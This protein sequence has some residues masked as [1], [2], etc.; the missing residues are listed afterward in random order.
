MPSS[1]VAGEKL[2]FGWRRSCQV[3]SAPMIAQMVRTVRASVARSLLAWVAGCIGGDDG[4]ARPTGR[5]PG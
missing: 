5:R 3:Q 1:G 2:S 4:T